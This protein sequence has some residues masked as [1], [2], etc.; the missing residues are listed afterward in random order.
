MQAGQA[1]TGAGISGGQLGLQGAQAGLSASTAP[2]TY[3]QQLANLYGGIGG[4]SQATPNFSG[5]IGQQTTS[6][7]NQTN[8]G[9]QL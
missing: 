2:M 1:L 4:T 3:L 6:G 7:T 9:I 8:A 5:T